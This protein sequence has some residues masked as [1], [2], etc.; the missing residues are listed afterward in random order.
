MCSELDSHQAADLGL[1]AAEQAA[2]GAAY[3]S[4]MAQLYA[5]LTARGAY[6]EQ[7]FTSVGAPSSQA[8]CHS[9]FDRLC[10][11]ASAPASLLVQIDDNAAPL[12]FVTYLLGRGDYGYYGR[13]WRGG[14]TQRTQPMPPPGPPIIWHAELFDADYGTPTELCH[15]TAPNSGVFTRDWT[16][17]TISLDCNT[18]TP[19]IT[20]K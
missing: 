13:S 8:G 17:A 1:S 14:C 9:L 6:T 19:T 20:M 18:W 12:S 11:P 16:K 7:Q 15:E 4:S 10:T 2:L 3:A 5:Q